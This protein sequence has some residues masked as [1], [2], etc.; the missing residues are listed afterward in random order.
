MTSSSCLECGELSDGPRCDEHKLTQK[1]RKRTKFR[2]NPTR[3]KKLSAR[4]R[5]MQ[6]WCSSCGASDDLT[7]DHIIPY[8]ERPDLA[9]D[10][11]NLDVL[12]RRCNSAKS[13]R[14]VT[15]ANHVLPPPVKPEFGSLSTSRYLGDG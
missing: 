2:S 6:P 5:R 13:T 3:W 8:S 4:L 11:T 12:C 1:P 7:V 10:I 9:Y 15:P 14:G